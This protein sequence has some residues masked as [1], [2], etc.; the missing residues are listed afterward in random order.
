MTTSSKKTQKIEAEFQTLQQA[1]TKYQQLFIQAGDKDTEEQQQIDRM[2]QLIETAKAEF[3]SKKTKLDKQADE[4]QI[5]L[6]VLTNIK[7]KANELLSALK[8]G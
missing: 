1:L 6:N 2:Q 3:F 8:Q 7:A 4:E 5:F